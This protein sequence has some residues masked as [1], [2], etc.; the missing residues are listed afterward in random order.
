VLQKWSCVLITV[1]IVT[2]FLT[3]VIVTT[4]YSKSIFYT[5]LLLLEGRD[6]LC[7]SFVFVL[8]RRGLDGFL[9]FVLV[10]FFLSAANLRS[11]RF[12]AFI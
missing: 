4:F 9:P 11:L 12:L 6:G 10:L 8:E 5:I 2:T 3:V 1:V 7:L